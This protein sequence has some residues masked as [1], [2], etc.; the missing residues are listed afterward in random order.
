[1]NFKIHRGTQEIGGSCVEIWTDTTKIIVDIGMP[2]VA[3]DGQQF[4]FKQ[5]ENLTS[6][7][8]VQKGILPDIEGLYGNTDAKVDGILISH[9]HQD[10][11][12]FLFYANTSI[13]IFTG[14]ATQSILEFSEEFF[15]G[16]QLNNQFQ[17]FTK[18]KSFSIGDITIQPY[19]MDHSAFD[20]YAFLME[21]NGK[22][23]FYSGDFRG[24]GRKENVFRWFLQNAPQNV[25]YLLMEGTTIGR[26]QQR[27]QTEKELE[28]VFIDI[29]NSKQEINL[30]NTSA[31]NIDRLVTI[32]RACKRTDKLMVVDVYTAA[33]MKEMAEYATIPFP[34]PKFP[35]VKV[36][37]PYFLSKMI[38]DKIGKEFLYQFQPYKITKEEISEKRKE[39][40]FLI[41]PS[42]KMDIDRI[43]KM[44]NG[45][46]IYSMWSG[47]LEQPKT[48]SFIEYLTSKGFSFHQVHTSGHADIETLKEMVNAM[49]PKNLVPI[50]TFDGDI[51]KHLFK[52][53][54]V[55]RA[56]D[57][58]IIEIK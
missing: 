40:V 52:N 13:P 34:S 57:R 11:H 4:D 28:D 45:N 44:E 43:D 35:E 54:N 16:Q 55:K 27:F 39:I 49:K 29:F 5:Y 58:E 36:M 23:L 1:M 15:N 20:A 9:Y 18:D 7:E 51:Y 33:I 32:Y 14:K 37:Y 24:H 31:Q 22:R 10:H 2:L 46:F 21:A 30:I 48:K 8:L 53:V 26:G 12:G 3:A 6:N 47:Y 17:N 19:W 38:A 41:R 56:A 42:M 50:H 25:D